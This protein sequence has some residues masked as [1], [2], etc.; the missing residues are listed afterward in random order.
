MKTDSR[1]AGSILVY[2]MISAALVTG[3]ALL[4]GSFVASR[5]KLASDAML[6]A[7]LRDEAMSATAM[8][9]WVIDADTNGVDHLLEAWAG[10]RKIGSVIVSI[11][12]ELARLQFQSADSVTLGQLILYSSGVSGE[13]AMGLANML[14]TWWNATRVSET[15]RVLSAEEELLF[16]PTPSPEALVATLPRITVL[17]EGKINVNTIEREVFISLVL[18]T[19]ADIGVAEV[20]FARIVRSRNRGEWFES[21]EIPEARKLL[22]GEGDALSVKEIAVL[23]AIMPKLCVESG[24]FRI[25]ATAERGGVRRIVQCIYMRGTG[26]ILR[27]LEV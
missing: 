24:L 11:S 13:E 20:M 8:S 12:D 15:N 18:S 17:G 26:R 16:A 10:E 2:M 23:Q 14:T 19:G 27:W 6:R 4:T 1:C 7:Q 25:T 21:L 9:A 22:A 3:L 5:S